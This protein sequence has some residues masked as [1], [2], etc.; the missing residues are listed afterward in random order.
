MRSLTSSAAWEVDRA[1]KASGGFASARIT[2]S[3]I[4]RDYNYF[5]FASN[6]LEEKR[7]WIFR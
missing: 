5:P 7:L 2:G 6:C 3:W 1:L 4:S